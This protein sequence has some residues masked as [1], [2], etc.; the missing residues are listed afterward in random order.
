MLQAAK[1]FFSPSRIP[2]Q[3]TSR[4]PEQQIRITPAAASKLAELL[5]DAGDDASGIRVFVSGGGCNGMTYG[6]TYADQTTEYD[7]VIEGADYKLVVDVVAMNYLQGCEIDF[8]PDSPTPSF[9]FHNAFQS[10]GGTGACG[11][12][13]TG[14]GGCGSSGGGGGC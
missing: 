6:F 14:G 13:G 7:R 12:S 5:A 10:I 9:V 4:I 11:S 1:N 8:P 2:E 3:Q